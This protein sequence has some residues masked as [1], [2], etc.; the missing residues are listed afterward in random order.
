[1]TDRRGFTLVEILVVMSII[2]VLAVMIIPGLVKSRYLAKKAAVRSEI[3][4]IETAINMYEADYGG[5]PAEAESNSSRA[6][7]DALNGDRKAEPPRKNYFPFKAKRIINGEYYSELK[8]PFYY[9]ENA[10]EK[11]KTDEMKKADTYDIWTHDAKDDEFGIN[12]WD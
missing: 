9:R 3:A 10:S 2:M 11:T 8:R 7:V 5:Y 1:M 4:N 12:N 6:L